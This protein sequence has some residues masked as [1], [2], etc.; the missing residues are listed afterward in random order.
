[1]QYL[2]PRFSLKHQVRITQVGE[3]DPAQAR[4]GSEGLA[5]F[6]GLGQIWALAHDG[7][8]GPVK[9]ADWLRSSVGRDTIASFAPEGTALFTSDIAPK[10]AVAELQFDGDPVAGK[11]L[12]FTHCARCHVIDASNKM[13]GMGATPSFGMLRTLDDWQDRFTS[14]YVRNPHPSFT[15][16]ADISPPFDP[17]RPPPIVPLEITQDDLEAILAFVATVPAADLGDPIQIQ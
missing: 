10:V 15:Q 11:K 7:G 8:A 6:E 17:A 2:L 1:M 3:N 4:F 5:V 16:V 13:K 14:F 9:F 12:S